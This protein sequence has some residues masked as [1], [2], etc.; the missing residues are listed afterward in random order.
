M[1]HSA[2]NSILLDY[3]VLLRTLE[4]VEVGH[5]EYAA[6]AHG[7]HMRMESFDTYFGL[8]LPYTVFSAAKQFSVNLQAKNITVQEAIRGAKLLVSH[9]KSLR[10]E[11]HFD[12]FYD[13]TL[14]QSST[15]TEEPQLPRY[16]K[17]PIRLDEGDHPHR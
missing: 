8:K 3:E 5:D 2:I 6:K 16:R 10:T 1:R 9:L 15:L 14:V 11:A 17:L 13:Q 12:K 4:T 7:L